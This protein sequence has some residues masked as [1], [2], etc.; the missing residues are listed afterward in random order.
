VTRNGG[1]GEVVVNS[2]TGSVVPAGDARAMADAI[3]RYADDENLLR[4]HGQAARER[5]VEE[6]SIERCA[7]AY[8]AAMN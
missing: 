8:V 3:A 7:S 6:F 1:L 5:A 2:K 4:A